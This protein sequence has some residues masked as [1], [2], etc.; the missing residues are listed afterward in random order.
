[1]YTALVFQS[2]SGPFGIEYRKLTAAV[3]VVCTMFLVFIEKSSME[4]AEVPGQGS[5]DSKVDSKS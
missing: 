1:M 4:V 5:R 2:A 3:I